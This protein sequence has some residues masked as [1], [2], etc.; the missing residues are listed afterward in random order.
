M[1]QTLSNFVKSGC[2]IGMGDAAFIERPNLAALGMAVI[3][4]WSNLETELSHLLIQ[5]LGA[6][7]QPGAAMYAALTGS[8]AQG[9]ALRA[10]AQKVMSAE[11]LDVFECLLKLY[12]SAAK[13]RN[14][15]AHW[16]WACTASLED[17]ILLIDP[18]DHFE[19][20]ARFVDWSH[21]K[22]EWVESEQFDP[23]KEPAIPTEGLR[24]DRIFV[25]RERDFQEAMHRIGRLTLLIGYMGCIMTRHHPASEGGQVLALLK[26]EPEVR[27]L[28]SRLQKNR[29]SCP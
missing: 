13:E 21:R 12:K 23:K 28:L 10:V 2:G 5:M 25:Y 9:A 8:A 6:N 22:R 14:R 18:A 15:L 11:E 20:N 16:N 24:Y 26:A 1:P 19:N 29:K 7:P 4:R 3:V 27:E 17:A